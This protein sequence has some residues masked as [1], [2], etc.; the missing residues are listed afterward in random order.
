MTLF[1]VLGVLLTLVASIMVALPLLRVGGRQAGTTAALSA[2]LIAITAYFLYDRVSD[3]PWPQ[4]EPLAGT[5]AT[6]ELQQRVT[7]S[8]ADASA[9]IKL[10]KEHQQQGRYAEASDAFRHAMALKDDAAGD[11]LRMAYAET[12]ILADP[13]ALAAD[14][15]EIVEE[16][17]QRHPEDPRALWFGG[18]VAVAR[19]EPALARERWSRLLELSPPP[20]VRALLEEQIAALEAA[21]PES[22]PGDAIP[23]IAVQ[24]AVAPELSARMGELDERAALFVIARLP[25][26]PGPPFAVVRR[27]VDGLPTDIVIGEKDVLIPQKIGEPISTLELTARISRTGRAEAASGDWYGQGI[28]RSDSNQVVA[29]VIDRSVE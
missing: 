18:M 14:A 20:E 5:A 26:I 11:E 1:I 23:S 22:P 7:A 15:G 2:V 8:P 28:W 25:G 12:A 6:L 3:Y 13:A 16:M 27:S 17:L 19:S 10:G 4:T 9:W 29:L 21:D 24:V